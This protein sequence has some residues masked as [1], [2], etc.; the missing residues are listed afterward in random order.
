MRRYRDAFDA[1]RGNDKDALKH[2][3]EVVKPRADATVQ[4][5]RTNFGR[6]EKTDKCPKPANELKPR[7]HD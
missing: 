6:E 4:L 2:F 7:S 5:G 1:T 3:N